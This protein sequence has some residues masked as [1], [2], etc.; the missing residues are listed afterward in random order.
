MRFAYSLLVAAALTL[1]AVA[2][3]TLAM[4]DEASDKVKLARQVVDQSVTPGLDGRITRM[5]GQV[6]E[7]LPADKQAEAR[8][9]LVKDSGGI[10]EDLVKVFATYYAGAFTAAEL[11]ELV[12]FYSSPIGRKVVEVEE[13]KPD[14]VNAAIQQQIMKLVVLF[15]SGPGAPR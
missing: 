2:A 3:P 5:I 12:A 14:E 9:A 6:V 11:K 7:K 4:A 15:N 1:P 8:A 10:R 13:N